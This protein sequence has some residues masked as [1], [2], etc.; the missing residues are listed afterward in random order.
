MRQRHIV[1]DRE[2]NIL[3]LN[4]CDDPNFPE[5]TLKVLYTGV[6]RESTNINF[7]RLRSIEVNTQFEIHGK[8]R[9]KKL[10]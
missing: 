7:V 10:R 9:Q 2:R 1:V 3:E 6:F 4:I 8:Q 5:A